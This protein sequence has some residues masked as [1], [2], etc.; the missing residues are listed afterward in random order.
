MWTRKEVLVLL[1]LS[2][3][4]FHEECIEAEDLLENTLHPTEAYS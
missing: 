1:G 4:R 3:F 2:D